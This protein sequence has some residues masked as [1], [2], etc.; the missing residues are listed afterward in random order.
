[1]R[2]GQ[3]R[4]CLE[5]FYGQQEQVPIRLRAIWEQGHREPW[6]LA[7]SLE[8]P[9]QTERLYRWRMRLECTNRD[10]KTGV[11]LR[12]GGDQHAIR[13]LLHMHR[14]LLA[15]AAAQWL[16]ALLGLQSWRE[17]PIVEQHGLSPEAALQQRKQAWAGSVLP[18]PWLPHRL[19]PPASPPTI[20]QPL[21]HPWCP[22]AVL[23]VNSPSGCGP[24]P[25]V[26]L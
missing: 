22:I 10:E 20:V 5:A 16:L 19:Q 26:V 17:L 4:F 9:Q 3:R 18:L 8:D 21:P 7:T 11:L 2:P 12:E 23:V 15:L 25:P 6:Y 13:S 24:L 14:L 1:L